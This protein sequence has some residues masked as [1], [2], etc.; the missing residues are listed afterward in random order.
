M[1]W[2]LKRGSLV[3]SLAQDLANVPETTNLHLPAR[4]GDLFQE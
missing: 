1:I 4:R 3:G 2:I